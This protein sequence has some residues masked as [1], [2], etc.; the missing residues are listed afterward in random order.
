MGITFTIHFFQVQL[1]WCRRNLSLPKEHLL[2]F[3]FRQSAE[4]LSL[5]LVTIVHD[6]HSN[7]NFLFDVLNY[8]NCFQYVE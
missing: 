2:R 4:W 6:L 1:D 7:T 8:V 5:V 3:R